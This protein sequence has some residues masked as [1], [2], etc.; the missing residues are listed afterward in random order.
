MHDPATRASRD[1]NHG[2]RS[3]KPALLPRLPDGSALRG[4]GSWSDDLALDD[5]GS[6]LGVAVPLLSAALVRMGLGAWHPSRALA[7]SVPVLA[8]LATLKPVLRVLRAREAPASP[9]GAG[10]PLAHP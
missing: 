4:T 10:Q 7:F 8:A 5:A 2:S 1:G 3:R 6:E 9:H